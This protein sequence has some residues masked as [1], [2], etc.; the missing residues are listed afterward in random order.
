MIALYPGAFKP[1]HRGHFEV[2]K[3]LLNGNHGGDIYTKDSGDEVGAKVLAGE[4][5]KVQKID[6][7]VIF[8]GGGERNG[9]T[10]GESKAIWEMYLKYLGNVEIVDGQINPMMEAKEYAKERP[11]EQ[12]YAVTGLRGEEDF[13][14][15]R[16]ITTFSNRENVQGLVVPSSKGAE[17]RATDLRKAVLDGSLDDIRD[18]FPKELNRQELLRILKMLKDNII[19]ELLEQNIEKLFNDMFVNEGSSGTPIAPQSV[20]RSSDRQKLEYLYNYLKNIIPSDAYIKF[21]QDRIQISYEETHPYDSGKTV[22]EGQGVDS[23]KLTEYIGSILEYMLDEGMNIQPLPEVKIKRDA[24]NAANFFGKTAYYDPNQNEIVLYVEGRHMK[25]VARSFVHEMIHH[26]QNLEGR[27][28][29]IKTSNTNEDDSLLELEKEAYLKGNITFRNWEDKTK[30]TKIEEEFFKQE[31]QLSLEVVNP[32]GEI[33]DYTSTNIKGLYTYKDSK[34]NL[35]FA[36]I[37]YYAAKQPYFEFKVGW[38]K[39]N[40][41]SKS[42]YEPALPQEGTS[43]DNI[44]RRNTVAKIYRD[45]ILPFYKEKASKDIPLIINPISN[46]RYIFSQRLVKNYTPSEYTVTEQDGKLIITLNANL[47]KESKYDKYEELASELAE[48]LTRMFQSNTE[49][50]FY[51]T[52]TV[53]REIE[54]RLFEFELEVVLGF[55]PKIKDFD[56]QGYAYAGKDEEDYVEDDKITIHILVNPQLKK[57]LEVMELGLFHFLVHEMEHLVHGVGVNRIDDKFVYEDPDFR[58]LI[59]DGIFPGERGTAEYKML[60]K[61]VASG[62][63][64]LAARAKAT[65]NSFDEEVEEELDKSGIKNTEFR[66]LIKKEYKKFILKNKLDLKIKI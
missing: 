60:P 49:D 44:K 12:F 5:G 53:N 4:K 30:N 42:T 21:M 38:F 15:L 6:K 47:I 52:M 11:E 50:D 48:S 14:D 31:D 20:V 41:L 25:D 66:R 13:T 34:D 45:E 35:Y 36:R 2:V 63:K 1:P 65:G 62:V 8:L 61:E 17:V 33:F 19:S 32:D 56:G 55:D 18:F 16:R 24:E 54:N 46:S 59:E 28:N 27:L 64:E 29:N 10:K 7:V 26:I 9:I 58:S 39:D 3:G 22:Y 37:S 40:D 51:H 43:M 23:K 57:K